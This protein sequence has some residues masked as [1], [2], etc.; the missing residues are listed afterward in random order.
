MSPSAGPVRRLLD[1]ARR[2]YDATDDFVVVLVL[3]STSFV[4]Y[5]ASAHTAVRWVVSG[6]Y[7]FALVVAF[8]AS[9]P[10]RRQSRMLGTVVAVG[11]AAAVLAL[12]LLSHEDAVGVLACF[13]VVVLAITLVCMLGRVLRHPR[14]TV[15]TIAGALSAY[16]II[17]MLFAAL[18][19]VAAW[20]GPHPF[21]SGS[22]ADDARTMQYFSFTTL[23]TTGYGDLAP[24][25]SA[26]R[27][28]ATFEAVT[29][30]IF[31]AT[32]VASLVASYRAKPRGPRPG[33]PD[34][35]GTATP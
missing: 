34:S 10:T 31:M 9:G 32:L 1:A 16:L 3:L 14:V 13:A 35:R 25:T 19:S 27:G 21:F 30:Q 18:F 2:V 6:L 11:L 7:L 8:R 28:L 17:G 26:G 29:G 23:T 20:L 22:E 15:Q 12:L 5:A 4:L 33:D 24:V